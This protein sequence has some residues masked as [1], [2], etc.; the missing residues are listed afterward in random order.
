MLEGASL[1][2]IQQY[3]FVDVFQGL[4][5]NQRHVLVNFVNG[6]VGRAQFNHLGAG[7]RNE[8]AITGAAGC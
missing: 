2:Q 7:L 5:V 8:P 3:F 4:N 1:V 6:G